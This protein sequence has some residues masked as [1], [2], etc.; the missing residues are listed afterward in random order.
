MSMWCVG[1]EFVCVC[2]RV[3]VCFVVVQYTRTRTPPSALEHASLDLYSKDK[4][5]RQLHALQVR[6]R[7][8]LIV[9]LPVIKPRAHEKRAQGSGVSGTLKSSRMRSCWPGVQTISG[10]IVLVCWPEGITRTV[11]IPTQ[12]RPPRD[13]AQSSRSSGVSGALKSSRIRSRCRR[14]KPSSYEYQVV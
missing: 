12:S 10:L 2:L 7:F 5:V 6:S 14:S 3:R 13:R 1:V 8:R 4:Q 11:K 9:A